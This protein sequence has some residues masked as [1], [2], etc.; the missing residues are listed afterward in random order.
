MKTGNT[1]RIVSGIL[2]GIVDVLVAALLLFDGHSSKASAGDSR[3][4][5]Y[6]V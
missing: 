4:K 2:V 6:N 5:A 3:G 1:K